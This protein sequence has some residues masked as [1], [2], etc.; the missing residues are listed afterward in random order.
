MPTRDLL[1]EIGTE[2]IPAGFVP[3][4]LESLEGSLKKGL[5]SRGLAFEGIRT[6][7]TPRRLALIVK[8]LIDRQPDATV[9]V[10]GPQKKAAYD[11]SG[12]PTKALL[13]FA[14][15]HNASVKDIKTKK[16]GA[17]EH[18]YLTKETKGGETLS[19]LPEVLKDVL[20]G[21]AFPKSMRWGDHDLSFARPVHWLLALYGASAVE[22]SWGHIK[23]S[24]YTYGHRFSDSKAGRMTP[25]GVKGYVDGLRSLCVIA[26]PE[27]RK[28][29]IRAGLQAAAKEAGGEVLP[30]DGL[31]SEVTFL[32][33]YPV[34]IRGSFDREFL[35]LPRDIIINAMREHQR[36]FTVVD[37][38]GALLPHFLTV[39]NTPTI[40]HEIVRK[41]NERVL[42][43]RLNDAKFY[44]ER[45]IKVKLPE[46]VASLKGVVFQAR[47]GTSYE[48]VERF[49]LLSLFTGEAT[50][51]SRPLDENET[52]ADFLKEDLNPA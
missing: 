23:S 49:A 4:A 37:G 27:E 17:Q 24:S 7:G 26:D 46:R 38:S 28:G 30:D 47:L 2:E 11:D 22:L 16:T 13:G 31:L 8:G 14:L 34:V 35:S 19:I 1:F 21:E 15:A 45:D 52:P 41:G 5:A 29:I 51:F 40:D 3:R 39:A 44:F 20:A 18:V 36:Y 25:E 9:E 33:E 6:L 32:V 42:R 50:G 43:A 48:K 12:N 10:R